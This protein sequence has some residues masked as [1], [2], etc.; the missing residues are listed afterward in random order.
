MQRSKRTISETHPKFQKFHTAPQQSHV[1]PVQNQRSCDP[2]RVFGNFSPL[3]GAA[4]LGSLAFGRETARPTPSRESCFN[5]ETENH[6]ITPKLCVSS[7]RSSL[8]PSL[9]RSAVRPERSGEDGTALSVFIRLTNFAGALS[10][11][12]RRVYDPRSPVTELL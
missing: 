1:E 4:V 5:P 2:T 12:Q 6:I 8:F 9:C 3:A 10:R 11:R 7:A